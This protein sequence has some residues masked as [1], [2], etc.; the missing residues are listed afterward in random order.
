[1]SDC[2]RQIKLFIKHKKLNIKTN[3]IIKSIINN[4]IEVMIT[5][6][7]DYIR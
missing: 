3:T 7:D 2:C 5:N 1:M 4:I 6:I